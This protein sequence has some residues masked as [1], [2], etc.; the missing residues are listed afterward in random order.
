MPFRKAPVVT[1]SLLWQHLLSQYCRVP[2]YHQ[3]HLAA[4]LHADH[5]LLLLLFLLQ[6]VLEVPALRDYR[7]RP[8]L[9]RWE[10]RYWQGDMAD[11]APSKDP[12]QDA[13]ISGL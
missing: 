13:G 9:Q 4:H 5:V 1:F 11:T 2:L 7:V 8:G 6:E 12:G 10:F 3:G